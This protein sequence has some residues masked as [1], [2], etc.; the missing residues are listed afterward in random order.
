MSVR[1][2]NPSVRVGNWNEDIQLEE[3]TLKDFLHRRENGQLMSQ[4]RSKLSQTIF[5]KIDLSISRDGCVHYGDIINLRCPAAKDRTQYF[6]HLEPRD[7]CQL[8]AYPEIDKIL[9]SHKL[10]EPCYVS[11]SKDCSSN[12]RSSFVIKGDCESMKGQPLRYG[13]KF[14]ICTLG[15]EGGDLYMASDRA[16]IQKSAPRSRHQQVK[17]VSQ[18]SFLTE[19]QVLHFNPQVRMEYE[20]VP[21]PA[22]AIVIINHRYT[23]QNLSVE[24]NFITRTSFGTREYEISCNTYFDSH[25][26]EKDVNHWMI[27]MGVPGDTVYPVLPE[28]APQANPSA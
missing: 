15:E 27:M 9:E 26:A 28:P 5:K 2:Y 12:L 20:G 17:F 22:N 23:N 25:R 18:P 10:E 7:D 19:W 8:N 24:E 6:A 14:Y 21:V 11:G 4:K 3:D 16:T 1:T 13:Q